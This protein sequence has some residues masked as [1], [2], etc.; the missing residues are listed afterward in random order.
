VES[1]NAE[2]LLQGV[3]LA[4][5]G[6]GMVGVL[7]SFL[8]FIISITSKLQSKRAD[9]AP[10]TDTVAAIIVGIMKYREKFKL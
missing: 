8:V 2:I 9:D 10:D 3:K 4:I 7:L 5:V 6:M 1:S